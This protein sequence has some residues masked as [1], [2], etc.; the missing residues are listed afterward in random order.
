MVGLQI[1]PEMQAIFTSHAMQG[2]KFDQHLG[3]DLV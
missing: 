3:D 1:S 2:L